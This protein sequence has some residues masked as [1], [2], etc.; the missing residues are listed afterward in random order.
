M[1]VIKA[2]TKYPYY[3]FNLWEKD[4]ASIAKQFQSDGCELVYIVFVSDDHED[5]YIYLPAV[6]L[7]DELSE[8]D[9]TNLGLTPVACSHDIDMS[10][11]TLREVLGTEG[12]C[13]LYDLAIE[14]ITLRGVFQ[15]LKPDRNAI[16]LARS[17]IHDWY[18]QY[19]CIF[20][21]ECRS[22][23]TKKL[24][25]DIIRMRNGVYNTKHSALSDPV[26][27]DYVSVIAGV[28]YEIFDKRSSEIVQLMDILGKIFPRKDLLD[29]FML[30]CST[31]LEGYNSNKVF[32]IWWGTGNN[33]K[34]L[35]QALVM[36][37]FG[38]YCSTAPTSL[39]TGKRTSSSNATPELCHV[40]NKLVVFLQEPNPD[41]RI[42]AGMI[43]EMTGN[44]RMYTR[45]L[46]RSGKT[47]MFKAKVV[48][49]CN[50]VMEIMGMDAALR[51]RII[52]LPFVST[53]L[54]NREYGTRQ[55]KGTLD[56]N[57]YT[58]DPSIERRLIKCSSAFMYL[59]CRIYQEH[60]GELKIPQIIAEITEDYI[61]R[62]NYPHIFIRNFI[63]PVDGSR[64]ATTE[65]Y[66][67]FKEWFKRSYPNKR[68]ADLEV[69][70]AE[71]ASEG[72]RDDG[73]IVDNGYSVLYTNL[74]HSNDGKMYSSA[75]TADEPVSNTTVYTRSPK[76]CCALLIRL[77]LLSSSPDIFADRC[78]AV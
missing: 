43:K 25:R 78:S 8:D 18:L 60:K 33:A 7:T 46:F 9:V 44:D 4:V 36:R 17:I 76:V 70:T 51:R 54:D 53:F 26:P 38:D 69:F 1:S 56:D 23:D 16:S 71:L 3:L 24:R 62:N 21:T 32:Y 30:S 42:K 61:T 66:E 48:I 10:T 6:Q 55:T 22:K 13:S 72:Y 73:G 39:I 41:E 19:L 52:V 11:T 67:M 37:A 50:N 64:S 35:V 75:Y 29:F 12:L 20:V 14:D 57:S 31:F 28:K 74:I 68:V 15:S 63:C 5:T 49:V 58:I 47:M 45:Q 27:S 65:I 77:D 2:C 34:S 59:L 40:E